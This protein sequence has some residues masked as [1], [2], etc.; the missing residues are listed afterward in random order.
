MLWFF[1]FMKLYYNIYNYSKVITT[2]LY[3]DQTIHSIIKFYG[4]NYF[5]N[6]R[7]FFL[8]FVY[9]RASLPGCKQHMKVLVWIFS[10]QYGPR[11]QF[12][13][14]GRNFTSFGRGYSLRLHKISEKYS[15]NGFFLKF[16]VRIST[17]FVTKRDK[18]H[19]KRTSIR[20]RKRSNSST[21]KRTFL[22]SPTVMNKK[23][24]ANLVGWIW[25]SNLRKNSVDTVTNVL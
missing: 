23:F 21:H 15:R 1:Q 14:V 8:W 3:L 22:S 9:G 10:A 19:V 7:I 4:N 5:T 12:R 25:G 13:K 6:I 11:I 24:I 20:P 18:F 16:H 2:N 17:E